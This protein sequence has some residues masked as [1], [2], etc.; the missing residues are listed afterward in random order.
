MDILNLIAKEIY[1]IF[2]ESKDEFLK[3]ENSVFG[4]SFR[5]DLGE[6]E[7]NYVLICSIPNADKTKF[8]IKRKGDIL[9]VTGERI[10]YPFEISHH[11]EILN[12]PFKRQI[13]LPCDTG[14]TIASKY[15]NG[16]L[17]ISFQKISEQV[18]NINVN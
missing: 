1:P 17:V 10:P 2:E 12:G 11:S 7:G 16:E 9:T 6:I 3:F 13:E 14:D 5:Y 15:V 4:S 18:E 8:D